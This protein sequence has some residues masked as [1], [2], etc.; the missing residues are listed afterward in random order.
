VLDQLSVFLNDPKKLVIGQNLKFD[1]S[2]LARYGLTI[3]APIAD[4]ML[5]S[6][7]YNSVATRHNMDDLAQKYLNRKTVKFEEVAGKGVKQRT[8]NQIELEAAG[9]YLPVARGPLAENF[10]GQPIVTGIP[11]S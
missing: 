3:N 7:V 9:H 11:K 10:R 8:F 4:T 6:Y 1:M 2:I 5:E